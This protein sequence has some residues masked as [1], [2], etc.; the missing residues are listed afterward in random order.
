VSSAAP[1]WDAQT[2][3]LAGHQFVCTAFIRRVVRDEL[4]KCLRRRVRSSSNS[5]S[6]AR[7]RRLLGQSWTG[8]CSGRQRSVGVLPKHQLASEHLVFPQLLNQFGTLL[9]AADVRRVQEVQRRSGLCVL[10]LP[11]F[12]LFRKLPLQSLTPRAGLR[13]LDGGNTGLQL[14]DVVQLSV[15]CVEPFLASV[16][17]GCDSS[18]TSELA[19]SA[20][21]GAQWRPPV[22]NVQGPM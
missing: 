6:R 12:D 1:P 11:Q 7:G 15:E 13:V 18:R 16:P 19:V 8:V 20:S 22:Q 9:L 5:N 3:D 10:F 21:F 2:A 17:Q 4:V 14:V